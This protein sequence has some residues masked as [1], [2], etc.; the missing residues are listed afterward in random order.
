MH[1][2]VFRSPLEDPVKRLWEE[3]VFP[4]CQDA[5]VFLDNAMAEALH[6]NG[7]ASKLF[8]SGAVAVREFSFFEHGSASEPKAL[9]IISTPLTEQ[10]LSTLSSMVRASVFTNVNVLTSCPPAA[11]ILA[12]YGTAEGS[13]GQRAFLDVEERLLDWMGNVTFIAEIMYVP[14]SVINVTP[15]FFLMPQFHDVFPPLQ[16]Q[17]NTSQFGATLEGASFSR[18]MQINVKSLIGN[19][20]SIFE[21]AHIR[22]ETF[23]IGSLSRIVGEELCR[24]SKGHRKS[25]ESKVSLLLLDRTLDMAGS[26]SASCESFLDTLVRVLPPFPGH[27][28]D[29][30]I[31]MRCISCSPEQAIPSETVCPGCLAHEDSKLAL[32]HIINCKQKECMME[33]NRLL[34]EAALKQ[35]VRLD[36]T[37][38]L[39]AEQLRKRVLQFRKDGGAAVVDK[40]LIQQIF[41]AAQAMLEGRYSKL[42]DLLSTE[43]VLV[44]NA[45]VSSEAASRSLVQLLHSSNTTGLQLEDIIGLLAVLC[46]LYGERTLGNE[47]DRRTLK[48]EIVAAIYQAAGEGSLPACL[49]HFVS[50]ELEALDEN[51]VIRKVDGIFHA[52]QSLGMARAQLQKYRSIIEEGNMV[53]PAVYKPLLK[54]VLLD[55]FDS[56]ASAVP[57]I[58]YHSGGLGD[59]FKAGFGLFRSASKPMPKDSPVIIIFIVGGV[60]ASE[61]KLVNDITSSRKLTQ[62]VIIGS[63]T[64]AKPSQQLGLL[65]G[66]CA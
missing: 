38:R 26:L 4:R 27:C 53:Q 14:L 24:L 65:F 59:I 54:Q 41:G 60:T 34:V 55:V 40:G 3:E 1:Q 21:V 19:L 15:K 43:K 42:E 52:L 9:F 12:K 32:Q 16:E 5:V 22:E 7:G 63:T 31:D 49:E 66:H 6:W 47:S 33:L 46:S 28:L 61:V 2:N 58:D 23:S 29:V 20:N 35:G 30:C 56:S 11:Q 13:D 51:A 64:L 17:Y 8:E 25:A 36:V 18:S 57:D 44:Q 37:G 39:T 45:G 50:D 48:A 10:T 62:Q